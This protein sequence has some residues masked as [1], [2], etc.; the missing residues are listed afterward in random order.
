PALGRHGHRRHPP[1]CGRR[2]PLHG[3]RRRLRDPTTEPEPT[4]LRLPR[5]LSCPS[6]RGGGSS[7][8]GYRFLCFTGC[9][10]R[11][12][13]V[14]PP[15]TRIGASLSG[16]ERGGLQCFLRGDA[17]GSLGESWGGKF[18]LTLGCGYQFGEDF[19]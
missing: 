16:S 4:R 19:L 15:E 13:G 5:D 6:H 9:L 14:P 8:C 10:T 11:A 2:P 12:P 3:G 1:G 18:A 17:R 7:L